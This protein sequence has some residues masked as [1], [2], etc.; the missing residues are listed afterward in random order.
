MKCVS[1]LL[2]FWY[3]FICFCDPLRRLRWS[4]LSF[5]P[6]LSKCHSRRLRPHFW[7]HGNKFQMFQQT[8]KR[9]HIDKD[10]ALGFPQHNDKNSKHFNKSNEVKHGVHRAGGWIVASEGWTIDL[11][12]GYHYWRTLMWLICILGVVIIGGLID[13]DEGENWEEIKT[14]TDSRAGMLVA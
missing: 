11:S 10:T 3:F 6:T 13:L 1:L 14:W 12:E 9:E 8:R 5:L 7:L 4:A 2:L